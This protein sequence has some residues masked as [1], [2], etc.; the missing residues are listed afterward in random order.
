MEKN[1]KESPLLRLPAEIRNHIFEM[2]LDGHTIK[3]DAPR[4]LNNRDNRFDLLQSCRQIYAETGILPYRLST[5]SF[6]YLNTMKKW[7][8]RLPPIQ[9]QAISAIQFP[10]RR[11]WAEH[12]EATTL[13]CFPNLP[14]LKNVD[15]ILLGQAGAEVA[16]NGA[17]DA[18]KRLEEGIRADNHALEVKIE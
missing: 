11:E 3:P 12:E 17:R 2:A 16:C 4:T 5:F 7:C 13:L 10:Y 9:R 15:V 14:N 18:E 1:A 8:D 6:R